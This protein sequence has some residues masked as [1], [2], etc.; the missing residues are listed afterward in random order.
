MIGLW[1]ICEALWTALS[2]M[3]SAVQKK[4]NSLTDR[5]MW[6]IPSSVS[7]VLP[8]LRIG[9]PAEGGGEL[10]VAPLGLAEIVRCGIDLGCHV[11][12]VNSI[13]CYHWEKMGTKIVLRSILLQGLQA[14]TCWVSLCLH[15]ARA[16]VTTTFL[17][18]LQEVEGKC[19]WGGLGWNQSSPRYFHRNSC[20]RARTAAQ[21]LHY[22]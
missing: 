5:R 7:P 21:L 15:H 3:K 6:C 19:R 16:Q 8:H 10:H 9:L 13:F 18:S 2:C 4:L 11:Q 17:L 22:K 12:H 1:L 20:Q 14:P